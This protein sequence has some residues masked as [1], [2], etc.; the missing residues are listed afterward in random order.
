LILKRGAKIYESQISYE[1]NSRNKNENI[2]KWKLI[3]YFYA[4][5][6]SFNENHSNNKIK[7]IKI[8]WTPLRGWSFRKPIFSNPLEENNTTV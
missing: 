7:E 2:S 5:H 6:S 1:N 8:K 4:Y 3:T